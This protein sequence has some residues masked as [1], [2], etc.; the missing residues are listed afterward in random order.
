MK[1]RLLSLSVLL[2]GISTA[3]GG[4]HLLAAQSVR[5][6]LGSAQAETQW[7][8]DLSAWRAQ[9]E[10]EVS[11]PDGWLTLAGL[12]WLKPGINS[13]GAAEG[14]QI[15][16][17]APAP[18]HLGLFTLSGTVVQLLSPAGG[19]PAELTI[20]GQ[21][22]RE[23]QIR[24][25]GVDGAKPST[26]VWHN[27]TLVV[28]ERADRY[29]VRLKD[30]NSPTRANFRGLHW[31]APDPRLRVEALWIPYTP[32]HL[33]KIPTVLGST[34]DLPS[35]GVAEFTLDGKILRLEPVIEPGEKD[36]L[37]FILRDETSKTTT[38]Q[39]ARFLHTG[40][41]NHGLEE[42]GVL[43]LDFNRLENPPCAYTPYATCPLPPEQNRL[44]ISIEA[45]EQR[46]EH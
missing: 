7:R 35:P 45:G 30:V 37:F 4:F 38:Y 32:P 26:I 19:F 46:Y 11:A 23:G 33:D 10:T 1:N 3:T 43:I 34:L 17:P 2:F 29:V 16:L 41:P 9:R 21:P 24:I 36:T 31:F 13:V 40:L 12:D 15:K 20:D 14:S 39:A 27:L 6:P 18:A 28:L 44:A 22:A 8:Q 5:S 25:G 42:E